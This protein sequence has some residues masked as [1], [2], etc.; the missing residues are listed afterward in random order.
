MA[1]APPHMGSLGAPR[2]TPSPPPSDA[3]GVAGREVTARPR[4]R[5]C[6]RPHVPRRAVRRAALQMRV[7]LQG[8]VAG[9]VV[10]AH[11]AVELRDVGR[12]QDGQ[13]GLGLFARD[14]ALAALLRAAGGARPPAAPARHLR[15]WA[16]SDLARRCGRAGAG[17][18]GGGRIARARARAA[19]QRSW[20][21]RRRTD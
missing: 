1:Q 4:P 9:E 21:A 8:W 17:R 7:S 12:R 10:R 6:A 18:A 16:A 20:P 2:R 14:L 15:E 11:L 5:G 19:L 3:A 13:L